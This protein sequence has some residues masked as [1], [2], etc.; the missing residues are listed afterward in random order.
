MSTFIP[1]NTILYV[2]D[3][4]HLLS[5]FASLMRRE[6]VRTKTLSDSQQIERVLAEE[7]PFAV[8]LSDQ[9]MPVVDGVSVLTTVAHLHPGTCRILIT[10]YASYDDTVR[11]INAGRISRYVAKP[12]RD[13]DLVEL[14]REEVRLYNL[15]AEN[16][17]LVEEL[18]RTNGELR[19][20]VDGTLVGAVRILS[21]LL[22]NASPP[23]M[24][25]VDRVRR[26]GRATL[27]T[28]T[29]LN[30]QERWDIE[31]ALDLFNLGIAVLPLWAQVAINKD[32]LDVLQRNQLTRTHNVIA[33]SLLEPIPRFGGV[34][35][36]I[37]LQERNYD[38]SGEPLDDPMGGADIPLGARLLHILL[39]LDRA[40]L[41]TG[42]ARDV[43]MRMSN[44]PRK[45]DV[46]LIRRLLGIKE[47]GE[48]PSL[49]RELTLSQL[50]PGMEVVNDIITENGVLL[51]RTKSILTT[52]S[53]QTLN[54]WNQGDPIAGRI[55]VIEDMGVETRD[56]VNPKS[57]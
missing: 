45:Y 17:F 2:D 12:W 13:K 48:G 36:I 5:S 10:G 22:S 40:T 15:D 54:R 18:Q 16:R 32:G 41:K 6:N 26:M 50:R 19:E 31:R 11:A 4:E 38:G 47:R 43:I 20:L 39:D 56:E 51:L 44:Q 28:L 29:E 42:R 53:I 30:Q 33:A 25:Q 9:R 8:V 57:A 21:D 46:E 52:T 24:A 23:A 34:A 55:L 49:T 1:N 35:K 3:E 27:A 7:G 14:I 37:R